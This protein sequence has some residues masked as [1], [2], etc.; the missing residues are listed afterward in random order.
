VLRVHF[1]YDFISPYS[2][3]AATQM[4]A[5]GRE[6]GIRVR[7]I[8]V[9]LPKLIKLSEN[10][11]PGMIPKKAIYLVRDLKRWA[12]FLGVPFNLIKPGAFDSRQALWAA[13]VLTDDDSATFA[14]TVFDLMWSGQI[15]PTQDGWLAKIVD[16][17]GLPSEWL[18]FDETAARQALEQNTQEA[19][20]AGA[21]GAPSFVLHGAAGRPPL[22]WGVDRLDFLARAIEQAHG[23]SA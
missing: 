16:M 13:S 1:Y 6:H 7:W 2:Y 14:A 8:P 15:D 20:D 4:P 12:Q 5:F 11:P 17:G 18:S 19:L 9:N 3:L 23:K 10:V 21:F 22:F